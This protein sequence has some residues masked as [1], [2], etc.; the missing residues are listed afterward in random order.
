VRATRTVLAGVL[1]AGAVLAPLLAWY[2]VGS[3][4]SAGEVAALREEPR[5]L[6]RQASTAA[7]ETLREKLE[8]L[9]QS[10]SRRPYYH[11]Q[12]LYHDARGVS[13]GLALVPSPL[14]EGTGDPLIG[15]HFQVDPLVRISLPSSPAAKRSD[16]VPA[17]LVPARP[18]L[19]QRM[20]SLLIRAKSERARAS[21]P[22]RLW[23]TLQADTKLPTLEP[24]Q[25]QAQLLS[26]SAYTQNVVA[27]QMGGAP[28]RPL[29]APP[30]G[31]AAKEAVVILVGPFEWQA[32]PSPTGLSLAAL[33][34]VV[35]PDSAVI[36]GFTVA[37]AALAPAAGPLPLPVRLL[38]GVPASPEDAGLSLDGT[39]WHV[40]VDAR[41][42]AEAAEVRA[43]RAR[44]SFRRSFAV[45]AAGAGLAGI[46]L[47]ALVWQSERLARQ[48]S[49]LAAAAAHELRTPLA[50][51]RMY[52]EM[53][54]EG[55]G[56]P[57][58]GP[59][60]A[61]QIAGESERLGRVVTN[62]LGFTRLERGS[63]AVSVRPGDLGEAVATVVGRLG[64]GLAAAGAPVTL[65]VE[66]GLPPVSFDPDALTQILQNLLDNAERYSR[67]AADRTLLVAVEREGSQP[68]VSVRDHGPGIPSAL[69]GRLFRP[70]VRGPQA[71]AAPGL[72]LGLA[73]VRA[74]S[75]AQGGDARIEPADGGGTRVCVTLP[76]A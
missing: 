22:G 10:E 21:V 29:P 12:S 48:R 53:L 45:A 26:N 70:F 39:R 33:R 7:A 47:V 60:Y 23:W 62:L 66:P 37:E 38:P 67:D 58:K 1:A 28:R 57:A 43:Q 75:R 14:S 54:A 52:S 50:G 27:A 24:E 5:R 15:L 8:A 4:A 44:S 49:Q 64:P 69:V 6:A 25:P 55:L 16:A 71:S 32:L 36:Q 61:Q 41:P 76:L 46:A 9:R 35:T 18:V 11:Y 68:R 40:S 73:L 31:A 3:R 42:A 19:E 74:L 2:V 17:P 63:L 20:V 72:G 34:E 30:T 13:S 56:D 51:L 59:H 65:S